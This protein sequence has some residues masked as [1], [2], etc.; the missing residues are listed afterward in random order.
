LTPSIWSISISIHIEYRHLKSTKG[1]FRATTTKRK[2]LDHNLS[3]TK[4][5]YTPS[6][7]KSYQNKGVNPKDNRIITLFPEE[8]AISPL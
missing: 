4:V 7:L 2:S 5:A 6:I 8:E 3:K 1:K